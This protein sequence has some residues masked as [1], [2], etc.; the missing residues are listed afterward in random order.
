MK[1]TRF[2]L[3]RKKSR[4]RLIAKVLEWKKINFEAARAG[5]SCLFLSFEPK[6]R[7]ML[8]REKPNS[9]GIQW[10]S[11]RCKRVIR[12]Q[13]LSQIKARLFW[14]VENVFFLMKTQQ[15]I[16]GTSAAT[17]KL[18]E[19]HW[20]P[21]QLS[22]ASRLRTVGHSVNN[23]TSKVDEKGTPPQTTSQ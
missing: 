22:E 14:I 17:C 2:R 21:T 5:A 13:H 1:R 20:I 3:V 19:S 23:V 15:A 8:T 11:I 4:Q 16:S 6:T 10:G 18:M 7:G 9:W 12:W